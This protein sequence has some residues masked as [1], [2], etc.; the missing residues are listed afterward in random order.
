MRSPVAEVPDETYQHIMDLNMGSIFQ[1]CKQVIPIM[2]RQGHGNIINVG[3]VAAHLG[4][5]GGSVIYG[6]SKGA[7]S[8]FTRGLA[9]E[10][11][12]QN[13]RVNAL[14]PGIILTPFH[15]RYT[16]P[17]RLQ[18]VIKD[19]PMGRAGVPKECVGTV[20]YLASDAMSGYVTGQVIEVNGG[21]FMH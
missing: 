21:Q 12:G 11:V 8:T 20:F 9:M 15:E 10:L 4:G 6:T 3:S 2:Q 7:V 5:G 16:P 17:E 19:I 14:S 18:R 1:M 13:I